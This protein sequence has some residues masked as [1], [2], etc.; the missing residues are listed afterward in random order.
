MWVELLSSK[1][2]IEHR[3]VMMVREMSTDVDVERFR[4]RQIASMPVINI[5]HI[6]LLIYTNKII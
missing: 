2:K 6:L 5:Q 1:S 4:L 3:Y